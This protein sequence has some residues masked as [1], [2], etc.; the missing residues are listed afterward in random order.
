MASNNV[1]H[2]QQPGQQQQA[3]STPYQCKECGLYLN[4]AESL[5]VH[6]QYHKENLLNKWAN[7]AAAPPVE[8]TNNNT[9][10][11]HSQSNMPYNQE[12]S[13]KMTSQNSFR[14]HPYQYDRSNSQSSQVSSSSPVY[15]AQ[16]T[17]SPSPK[18]C[19]KCGY[20]CESA[21]QL[22][23]HIN[24]THPPTPANHHGNYQNYNMFAGC[25]I[26]KTEGE[27]QSEILDL[28]SHKVHQVFTEEEKRQN[29][30]MISQNPHSV[31]AMLNQ[32][33]PEHQ[34]SQ[35]KMFGQDARMYMPPEKGIFPNGMI[36]QKLFQSSQSQS[37][38]IPNG[39]TADSGMNPGYRAF[40][41]PPQAPNPG[42]IPGNQPGP[43]Q[44]TP[45]PTKSATWK[46]N[47]ARR[48]KTYNCTACNKWFTSSGHLKRHYNTTLHKN[49]VKS[50]GQPDPATLPISTHHHPARG[51]QNNRGDDQSSNSPREESR[52]E[53]EQVQN[54]DRTPMMQQSP[55]GPYDRP[56]GP[57][58][59]HPIGLHHPTGLPNLSG[60]PPNGEAGPSVIDSRGLLSLNTMG[61]TSNPLT[62]TSNSGFLPPMVMPM[63]A[64]Q[65]QMYPNG[66]APHVSPVIIT[67]NHNTT[68]EDH[69]Q[70]Y[71][72]HLTDISTSTVEEGQPL[73]SFSQ[74]QGH[75]YGHMGNYQA[76]VGGTGSVTAPYSYYSNS[77]NHTKR[78]NQQNN[79]SKLSVLTPADPTSIEGDMYPLAPINNNNLIVATDGQL[80][81]EVKYEMSNFPPE[82]ARTSGEME[83]NNPQ[84][85]STSNIV[86]PQ[87]LHKCFD[88]DKVF[89][90][91]CYLTQ[92]NK[93]FHSGDKPFKCARCGKRFSCE[94]QHMEHQSKHAGDKPHKCDQCPKQF[95]HKTDLRRHMCLHTGQKPFVCELCGKGFIRKDHMVKHGETHLKKPHSKSG[96]ATSAIS[97]AD[98]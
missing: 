81:P 9:K 92:H 3:S 86:K 77:F 58:V 66:D 45:T 4:S 31:S 60:S 78:Y 53:Q 22:S 70:E 34:N 80:R 42:I 30:E 88:C 48:P 93:T 91:S 33:S 10:I 6:L 63:E 52:T 14:Y 2:Y 29:A 8:E 26:I 32:W 95:N 51:D 96:S 74:I 25:D 64:T 89:N 44:S 37:D 7:Q 23:E 79:S 87:P 21:A 5:E 50:S 18:Q 12:Y 13:N 47:E 40:D 83:E 17:P 41:I 67:N 19:D 90:K 11:K 68:G 94:Q 38:F 97:V 35:P 84:I 20:V 69:V 59:H 54:F 65:Y 72:A 15:L 1:Q 57:N 36:D 62:S 71:H 98:Q 27:Q 73:P 49:A 56:P 43:P 28:D 75:R 85:T 16:P 55:A 39:L 76:D 46:S 61:N 24:V 82:S